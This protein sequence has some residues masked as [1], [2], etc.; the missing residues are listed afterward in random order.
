MCNN[1]KQ[2]NSPKKLLRYVFIF[3]IKIYQIVLSPWLGSNCRHQPTC[4]NYAIQAINEWG[5]IKGLYFG[6]KRIS[7]CH[8]W[9]TFGYDP[10]PKNDKKK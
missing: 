7:K 1:K 4:S 2:S 9:G 10:V 8:P 5:I 3:P 6:I